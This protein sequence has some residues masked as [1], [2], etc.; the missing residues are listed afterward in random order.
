MKKLFL[1]YLFMM[2]T[3]NLF[4]NPLLDSV[5]SGDLE[6]VKQ[7]IDSGVNIN[8]KNTLPDGSGWSTALIDAVL[9]NHYNIVEYLLSK[10]AYVNGV[11]S[12]G[13]TALLYASGE[14]HTDMVKLL[15]IKGASINTK[16]ISLA[17]ERDCKEIIELLKSAQIHK[18]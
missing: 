16:M 4:A 18:K 17:S 15:I 9:F 3:I 2:C 6:R 7:I 5:R 1:V 14:C 11:D 12:G 10:G 13:R 8:Q